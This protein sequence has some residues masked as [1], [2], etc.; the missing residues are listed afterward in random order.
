MR[1]LILFSFCLLAT[2]TRQVVIHQPTANYT[3]LTCLFILSEGKISNLT[4][5]LG[6]YGWGMII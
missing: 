6:S 5:K 4:G 2:V 1:V 3:F